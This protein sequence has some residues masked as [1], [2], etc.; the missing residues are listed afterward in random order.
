MGSAV[1]VKL[2]REERAAVLSA[3]L[4]YEHRQDSA[5]AKWLMILEAVE[6][7]LRRGIGPAPHGVEPLHPLTREIERHKRFGN[8]VELFR[9]VEDVGRRIDVEGDNE[10]ALALAPQSRFDRDGAFHPYRGIRR[11]CYRRGARLTLHYSDSGLYYHRHDPAL[12]RRVVH[13]VVCKD[14]T[15]FV[16]PSDERVKNDITRLI[17]DG[18]LDSYPYPRTGG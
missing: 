3:S 13:L 14:F 1:K 16:T 7:A 9:L 17:D 10:L 12:G 6:P 2:N 15:L 18:Y 8:A 4:I 11:Y 5:E